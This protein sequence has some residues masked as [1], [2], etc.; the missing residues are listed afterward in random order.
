MCLRI[1]HRRRPVNDPHRDG[2]LLSFRVVRFRSCSDGFEYVLLL[3]AAFL[4]K[5]L[6]LEEAAAGTLGQPCQAR[7]LLRAV[8]RDSRTAIAPVF[9]ERMKMNPEELLQP[10]QLTGSGGPRPVRCSR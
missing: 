2:P 6:A 3:L 7:A 10:V 1:C 8:E 5:P 9:A 4:M